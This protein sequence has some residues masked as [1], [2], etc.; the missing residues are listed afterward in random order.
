MMRMVTEDYVLWMTRLSIIG[1]HMRVVD[2]HLCLKKKRTIAKD[3]L[4]SLNRTSS[5]HFGK[6]RSWLP[7][8]YLTEV[9]CP[10]D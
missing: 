7:G 3:D 10:R 1:G 9:T 6:K 2:C 4:L 5:W 8:A